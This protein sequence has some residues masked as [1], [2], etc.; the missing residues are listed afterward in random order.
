[1]YFN[2]A[3]QNYLKRVSSQQK[4]VVKILKL[5]SFSASY[6]SPVYSSLFRYPW[7]PQCKLC[8]HCNHKDRSN[9]QG[10]SRRLLSSLDKMKD[11]VA[12]RRQVL[13]FAL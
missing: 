3:S 1:M 4:E 6:T 13:L 12:G 8:L 2:E 11:F 10:F 7:H 9:W 5:Q